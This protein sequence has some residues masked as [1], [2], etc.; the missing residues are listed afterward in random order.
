MPRAT[1]LLAVMLAAAVALPALGQDPTSPTPAPSTQ[2]SSPARGTRPATP[3]TE[4]P[5]T[6]PSLG[7]SRSPR[8][9][10]P[11]T[12]PGISRE[13]WGEVNGRQVYLF[14]LRNKN[15]MTV[16]AC[17]Y[18]TIITEV[19]VPDR[20]GTLADVALGRGSLA[21]YLD[22]N[23]YFGCTAG[24]V[25]NRIAGGK[26]SIDGQTYQVTTNNG[27]NHLHGGAKGFDKVVW[28][29]E[30]KMSPVGPSV[31]FKY[32]SPSGEEGYPG[33][34]NATVTYTLTADDE[35]KVDM[36]ANADAKTPVNLAH[37]SYWNLAGHDSGT[38][39]EHLLM[40]PASRYTPVDA[41]L[42]PTGEL[43]SVAGTPFDFREAKPIGKD[44]G[45]LP[46]T[47]TDPGGYDV[48][49]VL[50]P[51]STEGRLWR[52]ARLKDPKSGRVM[53]VFSNQ[54]GIQ[55]YSGNFLDGIKGKDGATYEKFDGLC[56]ETQAFPDSVNRQG[57]EGWPNVILEPK[58][59]YRHRMVHK[60]TAE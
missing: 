8:P 52:C 55:F 38:I 2:P 51:Q 25:A 22:S 53:E 23:P 12:E 21:E 43:A 54:P 36:S 35:L 57:V 26:F 41:T 42:I 49:F 34:L 13:I 27:P 45:A 32:T 31:T 9:A 20:D 4:A 46:A 59:I 14:T 6:D 37:H 58:Q 33:T 16:K 29:G 56:L 1:R 15:G 7:A 18:G 50:D 24:R 44:I 5:V 60:F 11:S 47:A 17:E 39:L 19:L 3:P 10:A 30:A 28:K 48:N 40:I